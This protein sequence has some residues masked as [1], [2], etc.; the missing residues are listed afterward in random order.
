MIDDE[1]KDRTGSEQA[2]PS[3]RANFGMSA[4]LTPASSSLQSNNS[5]FMESLLQ[6]ITSRKVGILN[7]LGLTGD[8]PH[9]LPV[10]CVL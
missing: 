9:D 8:P 3:D 2:Y 5:L 6:P 1:R 10:L 4:I 7:I